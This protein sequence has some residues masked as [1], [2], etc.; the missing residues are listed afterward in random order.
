MNSPFHIILLRASP[1]RKIASSKRCPTEKHQVRGQCSG[2]YLH[3]IEGH[4]VIC[5]QLLKLRPCWQLFNVMK[6]NQPT[7]QGQG[8][9]KV[10]GASQTIRKCTHKCVCV[11]TLIIVCTYHCHCC[12]EVILA[13]TVSNCIALACWCS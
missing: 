3:I 7:G 9:T 10:I 12:K 13:M 5:F 1:I 2:I 6:N 8:R 4:L 11:C